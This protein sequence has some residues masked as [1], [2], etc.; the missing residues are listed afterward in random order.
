MVV[1]SING[2]DT[3]VI[4]AVRCESVG[5]RIVREPRA[6]VHVGGGEAGLVVDLNVIG[7]ARLG[8]GPLEGL[9]KSI[10]YGVVLGG[11]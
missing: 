11:H 8:L 3:P 10:P 6:L 7:H 5:V 9:G 1:R 4:H 2:A